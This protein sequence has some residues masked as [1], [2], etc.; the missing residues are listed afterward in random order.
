MHPVQEQ[1]P[2]YR[3]SSRKQQQNKQPSQEMGKGY[4]GYKGL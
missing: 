3:R 1:D 2:E 4:E